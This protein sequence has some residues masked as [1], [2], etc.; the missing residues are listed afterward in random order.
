MVDA[1]PLEH[2]A[3]IISGRPR[4]MEGVKDQAVADVDRRVAHAF[5]LHVEHDRGVEDAI[6]EGNEPIDVVGHRGDVAEAI[7]QRHLYDSC[8]RLRIS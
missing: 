4:H 7:G 6:V 1:A 2:P 5:L 3:A 8:A